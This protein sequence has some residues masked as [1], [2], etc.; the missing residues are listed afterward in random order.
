VTITVFYIPT[1]SEEEAVSLGKM[2][3]SERLAA[4]ANSYPIQSCYPWEGALQEDQE[5]VLLL[6]T[7]PEFIPALRR[8]IEEHHAYSTPCIMHWEAEVNEAY[9]QWMRSVLFPA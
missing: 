9:G 7:I 4:C 3:V 1:G 5:F 2:A 8:F 6:K